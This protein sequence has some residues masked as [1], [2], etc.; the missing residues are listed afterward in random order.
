MTPSAR[1]KPS[2]TV[3]NGRVGRDPYDLE[4]VL[5]IA[6]SAFNDFGYDATSMGLLAERLGTS[7]SAVYYHVTG[8]EDLLRLALDRALGSLENVLTLPGAT[9]GDPVERLRF[10]VRA[11]VA[12]L[13]ADLPYVTVLLRVRGNTA[14]ERDALRR[15][16]EFDHQV[17]QLVDQGVSAGAVRSDV[18]SGTIT[19]LLFGMVNSIVDWYKPGK[20][21]TVDQLADDVIAVAFD[22]LIVSPHS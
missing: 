20:G 13:V 14:I 7:K 18:D 8:K 11:A 2:S 3:G 15:R 17:A 10:V 12:V 22:G 5:E 21:L 19:R 16:R 6:V 4:T 9:N 1:A